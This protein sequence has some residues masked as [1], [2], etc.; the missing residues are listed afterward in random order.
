ME[1]TNVPGE[2]HKPAAKLDLQLYMYMQS[3]PIIIKVVSLNQAQVRCTRN[4]LK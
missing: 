2:N 4:D 3:E 1:E